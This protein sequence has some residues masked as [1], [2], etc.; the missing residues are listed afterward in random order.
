[1][2]NKKQNREYHIFNP[3]KGYPTGRNLYY[4]CMRCGEV[5]PSIPNDSI[6]CKCRNIAIDVDYGR[7]SIK[8]HSLI[9]LFSEE[10]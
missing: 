9:R 8:D 7:I 3:Q 4:E 5:I 2:N 10:S 6:I 1:M